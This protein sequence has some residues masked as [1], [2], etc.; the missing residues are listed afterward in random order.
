MKKW[1]KPVDRIRSGLALEMMGR[2]IWA[3]VETLR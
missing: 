1:D 2:A 3:V